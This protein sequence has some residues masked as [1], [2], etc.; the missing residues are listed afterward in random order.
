MTATAPP[1]STA[2]QTEGAADSKATTTRR[3]SRTTARR[4]GRLSTYLQRPVRSGPHFIDHGV[5]QVDA[6]GGWPHLYRLGVGVGVLDHFS[7]GA[8]AHWLPGQSVP[9]ISP[10]VAVAFYRHELVAI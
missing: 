1:A 4:N 6:S 5:L 7:L 2:A 10:V 8:T 9:R 3:S